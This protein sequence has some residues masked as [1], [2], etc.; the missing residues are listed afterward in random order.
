[1]RS[2][3]FTLLEVLVALGVLGVVLGL[4]MPAISTRLERGSFEGAAERL[5]GALRTALGEARASGRAVEVRA[6]TDA[7]GRLVIE[8][9]L[10]GH[11]PESGANAQE[12]VSEGVASTSASGPNE[13][14]RAW[15]PLAEV[16]PG[17]VLSPTDPAS[18]EQVADPTPPGALSF[19]ELADVGT[20]EFARTLAVFLPGSE[21]IVPASIWLVPETQDPEAVPSRWATI[22][23]SAWTARVSLAFSSPE[24]DPSAPEELE[25]E[26]PAFGDLTPLG[27]V[28]P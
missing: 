4:S 21:A 9:A 10:A 20:P 3:G 8:W 24:R 27:E 16:G 11:A 1:M 17:V 25:E 22:T 2:R 7:S 19:P 6:R 23:I 5:A 14:E 13:E 12:E 18:L 26:S 15:R 28:A